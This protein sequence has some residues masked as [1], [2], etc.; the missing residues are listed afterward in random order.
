MART[1]EEWWGKTDDAAIPPR[2]RLRI[3]ERYAAT[4]YL[5]G[6]PIRAGDK[7]ECDH[8]LALSCGGE[9]RE[10]NLA[11]VLKSPHR[12]KTMEDVAL[13]A[14]I[15]RKKAAH[16]GLKKNRH[17]MM[18]SKASGWKRKMNGQVVKRDA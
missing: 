1:V 12:Q 2:V 11:P 8:I 14:K 5:S 3:F 18:G 6:R 10:S 16:L 13:K 7:W 15:Y 9:H 17:P 4:C